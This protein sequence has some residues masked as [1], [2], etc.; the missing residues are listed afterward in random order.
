MTTQNRQKSNAKKDKNKT[1][2]NKL[3]DGRCR[4]LFKA[5]VV[6]V[7]RFIFVSCSSKQTNCIFILL[8]FLN[9][10]QFKLCCVSFFLIELVFKDVSYPTLQIDIIYTV[11]LG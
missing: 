10:T 9:V 3:Y 1:K 6:H 8:G 4:C 7:Q 11:K 2:Q 5:W